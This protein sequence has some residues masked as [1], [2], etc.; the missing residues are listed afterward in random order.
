M[1]PYNFPSSHASEAILLVYG[2]YYSYA[3]Q[4]NHRKTNFNLIP[5][6]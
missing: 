1:A 4:W 2:D 6:I 3:L 5:I